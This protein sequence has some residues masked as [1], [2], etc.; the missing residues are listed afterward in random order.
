MNGWAGT[1][2][3]WSWWDGHDKKKVRRECMHFPLAGTALFKHCLHTTHLESLLKY[4]L[5]LIGSEWN[6]RFCIPDG[7]DV[8]GFTLSSPT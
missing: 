4:R 7:V 8:L 2:G 6:P 3:M 5:Q 1:E